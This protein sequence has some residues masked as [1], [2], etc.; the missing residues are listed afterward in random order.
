MGYNSFA[1]QLVNLDQAD[2]SGMASKT[3]V[4]IKAVLLA[5]AVAALFCTLGWKQ[6]ETKAI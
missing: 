4:A 1:W 3:V 6:G 2:P 5:G